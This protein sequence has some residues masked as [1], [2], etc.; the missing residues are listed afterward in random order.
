MRN[1]IK[2]Q[3]AMINI[4]QKELSDMISV[5]RQT[6]NAIETGKYIPSTILALK[7]AK[8]FCKNV[9]EIFILDEDD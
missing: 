6:I 1:N 2:V 3:R 5:S 7:I 4:T 8:I 9:E